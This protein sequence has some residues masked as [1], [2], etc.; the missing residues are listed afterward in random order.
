[1]GWFCLG[2]SG[3]CFAGE[4]PPSRCYCYSARLCLRLSLFLFCFGVIL[5]VSRLCLPCFCFCVLPFACLCPAPPSRAL[6]VFVKLVAAATPQH[7]FVI[8]GQ[9]CPGRFRVWSCFGYLCDFS[10]LQSW[11]AV[12]CALFL[13][14]LCC[15]CPAE[16][17]CPACSTGLWHTF[18]GSAPSL[19]GGSV[20]LVAVCLGYLTLRGH[21]MYV[22]LSPAALCCAPLLG[23]VRVWA[24]TSPPPHRL[25]GGYGS[26]PLTRR[27]LQTWF[28]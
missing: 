7:P 10:L 26:A 20:C 4:G 23:M 11:F 15:L 5:P 17:I 3:P 22:R 14:L 18:L 6:E 27:H 28:R 21:C 13:V 9:S 12:S 2:F 8:V 24:L 1:M 16:L 19:S 25:V